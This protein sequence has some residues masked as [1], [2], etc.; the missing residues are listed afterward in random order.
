MGELPASGIAIA[1][2]ASA[3][4]LMGTQGWDDHN[5]SGRTTA[6]DFAVCYLESCAPN[7]IIFTQGDNDTYPLWYAQEVEGI[8]TDVRV[9]NLSLL[10][11]DWYIDQLR[12]KTNNA[13]PIKMTFSSEQ[14]AASNRDIIRYAANPQIPANASLDLKRVMQFIASDDAR[15]KVSTGR[16]ELEPY[17][18]TKNFYLEIDTNKARE[19]NM[20]SADEPIAPRMEW[21]ITNGNLL[22]NDLL[23]LDIVANNILERPIY[24]AVS[25]APEAYL[26]LEKYFQLEGLTYRIVP[27]LNATGSAY[28]AP[29]RTDAMFD[30]MMKKFKFGGIESNPNIYLDENIMRMTVNVRG[31][32]GRLAEALIA[33]GENEKAIQ[34]LDYSLKMM[35]TERVPLNVFAYQYPEIYYKAGAKDKGKKVMEELLTQS[36]EFLKYYQGVYRYLLQQAR[37]SGDNQYLQ[38][39]Q[40][41]SFTDNRNVRE[42]LYIFQEMM[43]TAKQYEDAE[44][45]SK[46][47]K[48]FEQLRMGFVQM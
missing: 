16:G 35:P 36:R 11:V 31:N 12:Y 18:P 17:F 14:V 48:E 26:G 19:F 23:T 5:R 43:R 33:K 1:L 42:P 13:A 29:V 6:R 46:L 32:F 44:F 38:Q 7:A 25:V 20:V 40:Q 39:L 22:K 34:A 15:N 30:N 10:G 4:L 2:C 45:S 28:N 8:R 21:S 24:F 3:P 9:I 27:R 37:N 41:G 47:E